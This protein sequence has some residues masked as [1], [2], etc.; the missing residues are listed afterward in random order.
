MNIRKL[1]LCIL[2]NTLISILCVSGAN[3][4]QDLNRS[5]DNL[6]HRID[7]IIGNAIQKG[8]FPGC[9]VLVEKDG[10]LLVNKSYGQLTKG[11][12]EV[13]NNTL[14]DLASVS[15]AMG[16]L[17]GIM[18]LYDLGLLDID[19]EI[20]EYIPE[21]KGTNKE[22]ITVR[23][24][25]FH[26]SGFPAS[27]DWRKIITDDPE[28]LH[29]RTDLI[30]RVPDS[31]YVIGLADGLYAKKEIFDTVMSRI[32]A[33]PLRKDKS[34]NYSC[35]NFCLLMDIEQRI[36]GLPH[37][38]FITD[39]IFIPVG[40]FSTF[41]RPLEHTTK[42]N[43]AP[44]EIDSVYRKQ[45]IQGYV[46]DGL[47]NSSGGV[48]G[49]AGLFSNATDLARICRMWLNGGVVDGQRILSEETV[50]LFTTTKSPSCRRG[51]G[52]DK[53]DILNP[54]KSPT[55]PE[56]NPSVYGH[57]GFTG[58]AVWIDPDNHLIYIFLTNRV[59]P[60]RENRAFAESNIRS[61][62]FSEI[63]KWIENNNL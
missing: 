51:L 18:K 63:Y 23:E 52:F 58:T 39:S 55:C 2:V 19:A 44:T 12:K 14:Y 48:S 30:S 24:L 53:P 20:S 43:I 46:H 36:S 25:L 15:K 35:I 22:G 27:I 47:A 45:I 17:P 5:S 29:I 42:D 13:D 8:A 57:L 56:A 4:G 7:S 31:Q 28:N 1:Y 60:T 16:T 54:D 40:A 50:R 6:S 33:M 34:F 21:L 9:Q 10:E 37:E 62:I 41:Y 3:V 11:G 38:R 61:A 26:E 49:N 32:Y 59:N